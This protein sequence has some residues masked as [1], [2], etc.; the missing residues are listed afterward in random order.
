MEA[1]RKRSQETPTDVLVQ[2]NLGGETQKSGISAQEAVGFVEA[3]VRE[4]GVR[5]RGLMT[6]PPVGEDVEPYFRH[7]QE[8]GSE[9]D[10]FVADGGI[11][12]SMG[13]SGDFEKAIHCGATH[14]RVGTGIFGQRS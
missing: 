8:L 6:L 4:P 10:S 2:V 14:I 13:M 12:L 9:V 3:V 11:K 7:L 5:F 1:I